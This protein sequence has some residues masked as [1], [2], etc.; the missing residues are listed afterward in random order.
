MR[1]FN[2]MLLHDSSLVFAAKAAGALAKGTGPGR[3]TIRSA[4]QQDFVE[5]VVLES[6]ME[7]VC[8]GDVQ[9][10]HKRP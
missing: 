9:G 7:S 1:L 6:V 2:Q 8:L 3:C 4:G 10:G 5:T